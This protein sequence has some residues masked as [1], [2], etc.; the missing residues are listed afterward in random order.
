MEWNAMICDV[1]IQPKRLVKTN[2]LTIILSRGLGDRKL[3]NKHRQPWYAYC[4]NPRNTR[5][6]I[7]KEG[8][9]D[10]FHMCKYCDF[11][12]GSQGFTS[13]GEG[14]PTNHK[15]YK[16]SVFQGQTGYSPKGSSGNIPTSNPN[17]RWQSMNK[18]RLFITKH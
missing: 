16:V 7:R 13:V 3:T 10:K 9:R 5:V 14:P 12:R 11:Q 15:L 17:H 18:L 2:T 8:G 1:Y 4:E 6:W